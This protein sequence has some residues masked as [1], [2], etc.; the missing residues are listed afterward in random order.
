MPST[1]GV[2][3]RLLCWLGRHKWEV[4][5]AADL[6]ANYEEPVVYH[7]RTLLP[8]KSECTR[9]GE[10]SEIGYEQISVADEDRGVMDTWRRDS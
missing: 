8:V 3:G 1:D 5:E 9:C 4:V 6:E 7:F 10:T 2:V